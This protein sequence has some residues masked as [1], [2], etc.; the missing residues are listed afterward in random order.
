MESLELEERVVRARGLV[1]EAICL[2]RDEEHPDVREVL[3][4]LAAASMQ[5]RGM[6][7]RH[8]GVP[9]AS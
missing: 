6:E 2:L 3:L 4:H 8:V 7:D 1:S 5:L 9:S